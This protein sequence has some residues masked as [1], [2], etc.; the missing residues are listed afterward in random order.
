MWRFFSTNA[1]PL[2][3][4]KPQSSFTNT[5]FALICL[6]VNRKGRDAYKQQQVLVNYFVICHILFQF[7][8]CVIVF[9]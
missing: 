6:K 9:V 4:H 3:F 5:L 8:M 7:S 2:R 1:E